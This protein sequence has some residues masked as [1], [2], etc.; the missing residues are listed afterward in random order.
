MNYYQQ[1]QEQVYKCENYGC[2]KL[3][4]MSEGKLYWGASKYDENGVIT[5]SEYRLYCH[6]CSIGRND[7]CFN[8]SSQV[9]RT[10]TPTAERY[11]TDETAS[12][13]IPVL[14]K[15][16]ENDWQECLEKG[17]QTYQRDKLFSKEY[18]RT[19]SQTQ[20]HKL[21][22]KGNDD[23]KTYDVYLKQKEKGEVG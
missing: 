13:N 5:H 21:R 18:H 7:S 12:K 1:I 17:E 9:T 6:I 4:R 8:L 20:Q 2:P 3:I 10:I 22:E 23:N 14:K 15:E 11:K 16:L 19:P